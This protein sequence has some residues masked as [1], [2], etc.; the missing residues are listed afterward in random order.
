[1]PLN[2]S[3]KS[4]KLPQNRLILSCAMLIAG[5]CA[6]SNAQAASKSQSL[7]FADFPVSVYKGKRA[8]PN[9]ASLAALNSFYVQEINKVNNVGMAKFE[10]NLRTAK[11]NFAG[12]Y[13]VSQF[14]CGVNCE[15]AV[16]Y[17]VKTGNFMELG[18]GFANC[19]ATD[20]NVA[21]KVQVIYRANSRMLI[22]IG[23]TNLGNCVT[24]YFVENNGNLKPV[25]Q[26]PL[27]V[28]AESP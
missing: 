7:R 15:A 8:K 11:P 12:H 26:K 21:Q 28:F 22:I 13:V 10:Q 27:L 18:G 25:A 19:P 2:L 5:G 1:M 4:Q 9:M 17:D 23:A 6:M 24:G 3:I 14:N 16:G 20:Y